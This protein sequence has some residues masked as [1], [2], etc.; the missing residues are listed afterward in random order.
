M[1][2]VCCVVLCCVCVCVSVSVLCCVVLCCV[3]NDRHASPRVVYH[4]KG[5]RAK[6]WCDWGGSFVDAASFQYKEVN[7]YDC[8]ICMLLGT[9]VVWNEVYGTI[10]L[11]VLLTNTIQTLHNFLKK[12]NAKGCCGI[13][14]TMH[15]SE[16][17][18]N[19]N[20][21]TTIC[22]SRIY[23]VCITL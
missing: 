8:L 1:F 5:E 15:C 16:E 7:C 21:I 14:P 4:S 23:I 19:L 12:F 6:G 22:K 2:S 10:L 17:R 9:E 11:I 13:F 18:V 20:C 3:V